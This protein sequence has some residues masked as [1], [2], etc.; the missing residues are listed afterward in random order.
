M[1]KKTLTAVL[2]VCLLFLAGLAQ[3]Q[4]WIQEDVKIAPTC[5]HCGMDRIKYAHS[6]MFVTYDDGR[7][8]GVCSLHCLAI[9]LAA[10]VGRTPVAIEAGDYI[11]RKLIDAETAFW[12]I[13]GS[14]PGVMTKVGKWAFASK[15]YADKFIRERGGVLATFDEAL[16][17]AYDSL[18]EDTT[19]ARERKTT[20]TKEDAP[21]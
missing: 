20:P 9:D 15:V 7:K 14:K 18:H 13:G 11:S 16:K 3:A 21:K 10:N 4:A 12:V 6:R 5:I 8:V 17:A 19:A 1:N 2:T